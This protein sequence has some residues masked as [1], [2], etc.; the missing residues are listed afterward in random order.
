M[1]TTVY[2]EEVIDYAK[3]TQEAE[4]ALKAMH[5]AHLAKNIPEAKRQALIA[6]MKVWEAYKALE[7]DEQMAASA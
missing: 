2:T 5:W 6:G 7:H 1:R 3:P 4:M